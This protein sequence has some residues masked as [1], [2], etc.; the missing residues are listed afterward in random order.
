MPAS[1][2]STS[3]GNE[4]SGKLR[5][6]LKRSVGA[7]AGSQAEIDKV[8]KKVLLPSE[9]YIYALETTLTCAF[10][11]LR[12]R[13]ALVSHVEAE[14][15]VLVKTKLDWNGEDWFPFKTRTG[16]YWNGN[17]GCPGTDDVEFCDAVALWNLEDIPEA[18]LQYI[19]EVKMR[20]EDFEKAIRGKFSKYLTEKYARSDDYFV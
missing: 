16:E 3:R 18:K 2:N 15:K 17:R 8:T 4:A 10:N 6:M 13:P 5:L 14:V 7:K 19:R 11:A 1:S 9:L 12:C 20:R